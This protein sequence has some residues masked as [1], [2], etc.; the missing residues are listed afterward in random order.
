MLNKGKERFFY[1]KSI[2]LDQNSIYDVK[3]NEFDLCKTTIQLSKNITLGRV[4][5]ENYRI[6]LVCK[7]FDKCK[8][9]ALESLD[10]LSRTSQT[11]EL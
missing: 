10:Y 9:I 3:N 4:F 5:Y 1:K 6:W 8:I 7:I 2:N 11:Y